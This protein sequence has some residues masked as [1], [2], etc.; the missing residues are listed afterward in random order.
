MSD[1]RLPTFD[2][3][4]VLYTA[5]KYRW[6]WI[7]PAVGMTMLALIV[8]M[9]RNNPWE[10]T[11]SLLVRDE[12]VGSLTRPG[13]FDDP[14]R[15]RT[16]QETVLE[17][18]TSREVTRSALEEMGPP[19]DHHGNSW[20]SVRDVQRARAAIRVV[21]PNGSE[22]GRTEVFYI[23]VR[24]RD[25]S[26]A[27]A[28]SQA[29]CQQLDRR[30]CRLRDNRAQSLI[31]ELQRTVSMAE[32]DLRSITEQLRERELAAGA[33][34]A[35]LRILNE[36]AAGE[37]NL[38]QSL[39]EVKGEL[40]K[41]RLTQHTHR[42]LAQMLTAA[43]QDPGQLVSVPNDLLDSH[44]SLRQ[45]KEGLITARL[46]TARLQGEFRS[47]HPRLQAAR[48]TEEEILRRLRNE[49]QTAAATIQAEL[50]LDRV[51]VGD[52]QDQVRQLNDRL[53]QLAGMR[54]APRILQN[55]GIKDA[56]NKL[57]VDTNFVIFGLSKERGNA[58]ET[59]MTVS[60]CDDDAGLMYSTLMQP[61][62]LFSLQQMLMGT[63]HWPKIGKFPRMMGIMLKI[64]EDLKGYV[65]PDGE[66]SMPLTEADM[67][68]ANQGYMVCKDILI[69]AGCDP[70]SIFW[71]PPRGT[72][73][74][75]TA[76]IGEHIDS[77]LKTKFDNLYVCDASTFPEAL[78][79]P[80]TLT[81][82]ALGKRLARHLNAGQDT[83]ADVSHQEP[84][85]GSAVALKEMQ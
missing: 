20:P 2:I 79:R 16:A 51:R 56:G 83:T 62:G 78:V 26:R 39:V 64:Q 48:V 13:R 44:A 18:A 49:I 42:E 12:A 5:G 9:M 73:P 69:K 71:N 27:M 47:A 70:D 40:R 63:K 75:G 24:D 66:I 72:H 22:F 1:P 10:A 36:S 4:S 38:R 15:M 17:L 19:P 31:D 45:I 33:D 6:R 23:K 61:W 85:A 7:L 14:E 11:Q 46:H 28:F 65:A 59:P 54:A 35:E 32:S 41:A 74:C 80:P 50:I 68:R 29:L 82:I 34:L 60:Y 8:A 76:R 77:D 37:S 30:L 84:G 25:R 55:S 43:K 57:A 67:R 21:A 3:D 81:I 53:G 52:L 58:D